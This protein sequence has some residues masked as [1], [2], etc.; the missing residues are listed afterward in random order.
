MK[1]GEKVSDN[2]ITLK[3]NIIGS[4]KYEISTNCINLKLGKYKIYEALEKI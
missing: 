1:E 3:I 2:E 4:P